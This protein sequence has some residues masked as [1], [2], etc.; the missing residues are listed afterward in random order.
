MNTDRSGGV[1]LPYSAVRWLIA[2][3]SSEA[4]GEPSRPP[5]VGREGSGADIGVKVGARIERLSPEVTAAYPRIVGAFRDSG[6]PRPVITSG[7]D[8]RHKRGSRH[9]AGQ[10]IDIRCNHLPD[11]HCERITGALKQGLGPD[12]DV[13]FERFPNHPENDH[14]HLEHDPKPRPNANRQ[15]HGTAGPGDQLSIHDWMA[16][17]NRQAG[18]G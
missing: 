15:Q 12:F 18:W 16:K 9:Y 11:E 4:H 1:S 13:I 17:R 6:A 8:S 3:A 5:S 7:N 14:I 2:P 10:A